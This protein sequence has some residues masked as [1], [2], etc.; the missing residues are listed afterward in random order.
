MGS[1]AAPESA[2]TALHRFDR[3]SSESKTPRQF[4]STSPPRQKRFVVKNPAG[5]KTGKSLRETRRK[6]RK[7]TKRAS[8]SC[9]TTTQTSHKSNGKG[10]ATTHAEN[11]SFKG[12]TNQRAMLIPS[13]YPS[14][15]SVG[16]SPDQSL[17]GLLTPSSERGIK[18]PLAHGLN[19]ILTN[20]WIWSPLPLL[21]TQ[22]RKSCQCE[23]GQLFANNLR[24]GQTISDLVHQ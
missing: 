14:Y 3:R 23:I 20:P 19:G 8:A 11:R 15:F 2:F 12:A 22:L 1:Q 6:L 13:R 4:S 9:R 10:Q 24:D 16:Q 7:Q 21:Q 17:A 5:T 18:P